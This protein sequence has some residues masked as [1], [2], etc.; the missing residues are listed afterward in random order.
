MTLTKEEQDIMD[1]KKGD[2]LAKVMK[3]IVRHGNLF[4]APKLVDLYD[5]ARLADRR[6]LEPDHHRLRQRGRWSRW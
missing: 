2:V 6:R 3:T 4:G 1:G 5:A